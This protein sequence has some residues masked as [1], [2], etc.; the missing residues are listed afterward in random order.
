MNDVL[1][2]KP[3][4]DKF[5]DR[6]AKNQDKDRQ[7]DLRQ[8]IYLAVMEET[9][10]LV[11]E[12]QVINIA[13]FV[14]DRNHVKRIYEENFVDRG[15]SYEAS[16]ED[17]VEAKRM[18]DSLPEDLR[19]IANDLFVHEAS[20][21]EVARKYGRSQRWVSTVKHRILSRLRDRFTKPTRS[22]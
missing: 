8:D 17:K 4:I 5:V 19:D 18:L 1:R 16:V 2:W 12:D 21:D 10:E 6:Y 3:T 22:A 14:V 11:C 9:K 13:E 20:Q 15:A 7:D